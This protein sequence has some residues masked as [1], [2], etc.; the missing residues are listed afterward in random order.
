MSVN[1]ADAIAGIGILVDIAALVAK[2]IGKS[3]AE[4]LADAAAD[5]KRRATDP[6]D[7]TEAVAD[8][9]DDNLPRTAPPFVPR[10]ADERAALRV[11][12]LP[13]LIEAEANKLI[14]RRVRQQRDAETRRLWR[15]EEARMRWVQQHKNEPGCVEHVAELEAAIKQAIPDPWGAQD[16]RGGLL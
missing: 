16:D 12:A 9:I 1:T 14:V 15:F 8:E 3:T 10:A 5:C 6:T 4:V 11:A 13:E 7:E 2:E